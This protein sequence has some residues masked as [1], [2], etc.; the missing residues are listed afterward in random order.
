[1]PGVF[2]WRKTAAILRIR[3]EPA[4]FCEREA[5]IGLAIWDIVY[6][7]P[8]CACDDKTQYLRHQVILAN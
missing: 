4:A 2:V 1:R 5:K 6:Q 3:T 8:G 7:S